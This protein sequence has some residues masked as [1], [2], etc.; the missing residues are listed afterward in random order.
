MM[1]L[2]ANSGVKAKSL[3]K[4]CDVKAM[5]A[6]VYS[7]RRRVT[8]VKQDAAAVTATVIKDDQLDTSPTSDAGG[9]P[10][11]LCANKVANESEFSCT[12]DALYTELLSLDTSAPSLHQ[13]AAK[14]GYTI[15]ISSF[16][17]DASLANNALE[18]AKCPYV[19]QIDIA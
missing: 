12:K 19:K 18:F 15:A 1:C 4:M 16:S 2:Y 17:R 3:D 6:L 13:R 7:S 10:H 9:A 11:R 8:A 5:S 14:E